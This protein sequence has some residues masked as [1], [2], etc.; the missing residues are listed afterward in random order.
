MQNRI[1]DKLIQNTTIQKI[2]LSFMIVQKNH[3]A[4]MKIFNDIDICLD[5]FPYSGTTTT[6]NSLYMGTPFVIYYKKGIKLHIMY[7]NLSTLCQCR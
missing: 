5:T 3:N 1:T 7:L 2:E 6:C 4:Y